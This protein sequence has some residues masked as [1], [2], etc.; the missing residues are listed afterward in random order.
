MSPKRRDRVAPPPRSD[1][2]DLRFANNEAAKGWTDLCNQAAA[3]ARAAYEAIRAHPCPMP[4]T[5]RHHRLKHTLGTG[6]HNGQTFEQWQFEVT[7]GGRIWY[8]V[9][10]EARVAW[11][12]FAGTGHPKATDR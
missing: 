4:M 3:N 11:L 7:G 9:D 5:G 6:T 12:T 10:H 1:E 8:L 2:Y